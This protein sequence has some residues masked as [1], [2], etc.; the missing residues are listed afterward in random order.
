MNLLKKPFTI[1]SIAAVALTIVS[2]VVIYINWN[3]LPQELVFK[4]NH[5]EGVSTIAEKTNLIQ[6]LIASVVM[7][8][9]NFVLANTLFHRERIL[10]VLLVVTNTALAL[11]TLIVIGHIISI[12]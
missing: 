5:R 11:L 8:A 6:I 2:A 1:F 12:N 9:V 10:S 4:F 7:L 3:N